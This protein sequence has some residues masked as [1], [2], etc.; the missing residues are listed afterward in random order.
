MMFESLS[1]LKSKA[2]R[3]MLY[4][5]EWVFEGRNDELSNLML[6]ARDEYGVKLTPVKIWSFGQGTWQDGFTKFLI[7]NQTQYKRVLGLD[8]DATLLQVRECP[9]S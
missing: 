7:F 1:R 9:L 8:S 4:P 5:E 2:D 6:K 3:I